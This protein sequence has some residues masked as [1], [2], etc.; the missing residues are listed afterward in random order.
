MS[1]ADRIRRW[2]EPLDGI[3]DEEAADRLTHAVFLRNQKDPLNSSIQSI[4]TGEG[5]VDPGIT[6]EYT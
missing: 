5:K 3:S 4:K 1:L 6:E 2:L